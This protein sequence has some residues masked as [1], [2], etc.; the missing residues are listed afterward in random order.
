VRR[1]DS[2]FDGLGFQ[3]IS[4]VTGTKGFAGGSDRAGPDCAP[5]VTESPAA[6]SSAAVTK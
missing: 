3:S 6:I 1:H 2:Q 5:T 4:S